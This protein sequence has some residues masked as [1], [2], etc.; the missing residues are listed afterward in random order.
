MKYSANLII[1]FFCL[2][3]AFFV[4]SIDSK[5]KFLSLAMLNLTLWAAIHSF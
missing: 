5:I 4:D 1:A 2:M 3:T